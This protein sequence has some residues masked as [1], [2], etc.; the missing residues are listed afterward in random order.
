MATERRYTIYNS[1]VVAGNGVR[2][3]HNLPYLSP[4]GYSQ[5]VT[6]FNST[7]NTLKR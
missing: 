6:T 2:L 4:I 5:P 3:L 1:S 7:T